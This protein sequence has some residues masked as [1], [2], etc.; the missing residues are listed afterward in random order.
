MG[1]CY[2]MTPPAMLQLAISECD[3]RHVLRFRPAAGA[4][5][6]A[7]GGPVA[8][9]VV[10]P[11][12]AAIVEVVVGVGTLAAAAIV[13]AVDGKATSA[14]PDKSIQ[15][16]LGSVRTARSAQPN[17]LARYGIG[18]VFWMARRRGRNLFVSR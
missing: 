12:V 8:R 3:Q 9:G 13:I 18:R 10:A 17:T 16:E 4:K 11:P 6:F 2:P 1:S 5:P 7:A 15:K 14:F